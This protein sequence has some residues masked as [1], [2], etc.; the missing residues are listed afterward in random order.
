[1]SRRRHLIQYLAGRLALVPLMLWLIASLV[2]L[3]LRVAPGDPIDA[4][5]GTRAP[6]EAREAL[7]Q[8]LGLDQPLL[9]QY[10]RYLGDLLHGRLGESLSNQEP[11]SA[12][13]GRSLPASLELGLVALLIAAVIGLAVG[14]SGIARPEGKVD[15]SARLYG[16]GTYALPPFW[17]AMV[18]QLVFAVWLGWLPVG[19]RFPATLEPPGGSGFYLLDG[20]LAGNPAVVLGALRHLALPAS[21]LGL[22]LSGIFANALRLNLRRALDS[23]YVEAAR[24]RGLSERRVVLRHALPNA[25]LPVLTITGIT[26]ASL[27]GGA[28]LIEVTYSW[29]GIAFRLQ[30]AIGQ[31]DYPVVQGIVVVVAAL[32]VAVSVLVDLLVALLDPRISF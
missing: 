2:F 7:R 23:D 29:P 6:R 31:R 8:Q 20:L 26:V 12:V 9:V 14:F 3:L 32:V 22:L 15:L 10:G 1:M 5:L 4:L 13:I 19:G 17:A 25:L 28:L 30:E 21:T 24:S 11:V 27:I 18:V 16:I